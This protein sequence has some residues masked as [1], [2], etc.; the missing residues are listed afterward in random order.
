MNRLR[1]EIQEEEVDQQP[2]PA[3]KPLKEMPD[4]F[5]TRLFIKGIWSTEEATR[6][7]PFVLYLA[8]LGMIY[9]GNRNLAEKNI[10]DIDRTYKE[11]NELTSEYKTIKADL[12]FKSTLSQVEKKV[13]TLGLKVTVEPPQKLIVKEVEDEH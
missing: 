13:D 6:A 3:E 10:R 2:T 8:L 9:I 11:I 1:T 5:F 4:N 12:T 7:L